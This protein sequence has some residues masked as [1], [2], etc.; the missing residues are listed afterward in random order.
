MRFILIIH[1]TF[2]TGYINC[3]TLAFTDQG[4]KQLLITEN[5]VDSNGDTSYDEDVDTNDNNEIEVSEALAVVSLKIQDIFDAYLVNSI[6][7]VDSL[8]VVVM[9]TTAPELPHL[10]R[11]QLLE[12]VLQMLDLQ[13]FPPFD[14]WRS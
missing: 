3:Q 5:C 7:E 13:L 10:A 9:V 2:L 6:V 1:L 8:E 14:A 12:S 11:S 4:L